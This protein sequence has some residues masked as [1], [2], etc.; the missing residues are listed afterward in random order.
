MIEHCI[1]SLTKLREARNL[2]RER[3]ES[4]PNRADALS[5]IMDAVAE[6]PY[7]MFSC[8]EIERVFDFEEHLSRTWEEFRSLSSADWDEIRSLVDVTLAGT[9]LSYSM[10]M[11]ILAV[12][13][14]DVRRL[15]DAVMGLVVDNDLVD[16]RDLVTHACLV[17]DAAK[18][19]GV[20]PESLFRAAM[21][22]AIA[23]RRRLLEDYLAGPSYN[24]SIQSMGFDAVETKHGFAYQMRFD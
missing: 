7:T 11:A 14:R 9:L 20:D 12:R 13:G 21:R 3:R 8:H 5:Q 16:F 2:G 1:D 6:N 18:R 10:R 17:Y 19:T 15:R 24:K 22:Y 23:G 4:E